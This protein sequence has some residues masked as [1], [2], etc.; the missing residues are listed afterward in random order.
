M[1]LR[2]LA[3]W[4]K[5]VGIS[6]YIRC[7][8]S[9]DHV[10]LD[11]LV[12]SLEAGV[13]PMNQR[14]LTLT[15]LLPLLCSLGPAQ[16]QPLPLCRVLPTPE[17]AYAGEAWPGGVVPYEFA[18]QLTSTQKARMVAAMKV[19]SD[20][21]NLTFVDVTAKTSMPSARIYIQNSSTVNSSAVGRTGGKQVI[22]IRHWGHTYVMA[23][24]LCHALG[25]HHEHQRLGRDKY[26]KIETGNIVD[27]D[28][29]NLGKREKARVNF[30][31]ESGATAMGSYDFDS[32]MH[33]PAYTVD[34]SIAKDPTKRII[35]II[36]PANMTKY[37]P[38]MGNAT[39]LSQGD[40]DG[41]V[42]VYGNSKLRLITQGSQP[43]TAVTEYYFCGKGSR[44][45]WSGKKT[46]NR[47]NPLKNPTLI[48]NLNT[49]AVYARSDT[50]FGTNLFLKAKA[51]YNNCAADRT[52]Q[53]GT[54][55]VFAE[56]ANTSSVPQELVITG[57][58]SFV[59][60]HTGNRGWWGGNCVASV[61][62][63]GGSSYDFL[64]T[65]NK[66]KSISH[67]LVLR[68]GHPLPVAA[69]V[70]DPSFSMFTGPW[71]S[72]TATLVSVLHVS[73]QQKSCARMS[74]EFISD[75]MVAGH[76][77]ISP[78]VGVQ[79]CPSGGEGAVSL[80]IARPNSASLLVV[81]TRG[82]G[83]SFFG[84]KLWPAN[85]VVFPMITGHAGSSGFGGW[86]LPVTLPTSATGKAT[87]QALV[88]D[89]AAVQ[90]VAISNA[91]D[92]TIK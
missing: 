25:F 14:V 69:S 11:G 78:V 79:G 81:G 80:A 53:F 60:K 91:V 35:T 74:S 64:T 68:A 38:S 76:Q 70:Y 90:G 62:G 28:S 17:S 73:I 3:T 6:R 87:M 8:R 65:A 1:D 86:V 57:F 82:T 22:N 47:I 85:Y 46:I 36:D 83:I 20:V 40:I 67:R 26:V 54:A 42:S 39:K 55:G 58:L 71:P 23:H 77:G 92:I 5:N 49:V 31:M 15:L 33:Y 2:T 51:D 59:A 50:A 66:T 27:W 4:D 24:E 52:F 43:S 10:A 84:G 7:E 9:R 21:A 29:T 18:S 30:K 75:G 13:G 41:M 44:S 61:G 89:P 19:W 34:L 45:S 88:V 63:P 48:Q 12:S 72:A 16:R 37:E 56:I 32:V